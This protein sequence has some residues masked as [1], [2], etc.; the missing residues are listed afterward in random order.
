MI[1]AVHIHAVND[2]K[3][4]GVIQSTDAANHNTHTCSRSTTLRHNIH[5]G[6]FA[7]QC[8]SDICVTLGHQF[9]AVDVGYSACQVSFLLYT[10]SY[11]D[12][13]IKIFR[14]FL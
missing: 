5:S 7:L 10:I 4:S 2:I 9:F 13:F 14:I 3:R 8:L 11:H 1:Y 6:Y 12:Y